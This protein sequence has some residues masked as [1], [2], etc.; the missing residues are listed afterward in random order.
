MGRE[1]GW[2]VQQQEDEKEKKKGREKERY[3]VVPSSSECVE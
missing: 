1:E 2:G 3:L